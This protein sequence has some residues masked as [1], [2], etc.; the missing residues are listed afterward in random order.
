L[1]N[2]ELKNNKYLTLFL[3][4]DDKE[5]NRHKKE[6]E[7]VKALKNILDCKTNTGKINLVIN[8]ETKVYA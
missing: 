1:S 3:R 6:L 2:E 8:D 5:W 4:D 7:K